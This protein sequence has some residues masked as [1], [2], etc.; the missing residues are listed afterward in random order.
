[1]RSH[2]LLTLLVGLAAA[3][4]GAQ[5]AP[6]ASTTTTLPAPPV[7]EK[8]EV[9]GRLPGDLAGRWMAV[10]QAQLPD[11]K[12]RPFV[13]MFEIR[14]GADGYEMSLLRRNPPE[15]INQKL[16]KTGTAGEIYHPDAQDLE[17][18]KAEWDRLPPT[19]ADWRTIDNKLM[20]ADA[21]PPELEGDPT[22]EGSSFAISSNEKFRG[23][24][25][26]I[27][28]YTLWGIQEQTPAALKGHMITNT[29]AASIIPIPITLRG[30]V[31]IYR[32]GP[33]PAGETR[34]FLGRLLDVFSGCGRR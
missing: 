24:Q 21:Y 1:M 33:P 8:T 5:E 7:V 19:T 32:I 20:G 14:K 16:E 29:M 27:S 15:V 30:E 2:L 28:T 26:I 10:S 13:R 31:E 34:S 23:A 22:V 11:G 6:P 17:A 3:P 12:W 18:V 4:V 9:T 25:R